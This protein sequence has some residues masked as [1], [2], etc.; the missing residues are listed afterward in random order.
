MC[1]FPKQNLNYDSPSYKAGIKFYNCGCCPE[2]LSKRS[3]SW[4]LRAVYEAKQ[5]A[6]NC[7]V[8]LTYDQFKRNER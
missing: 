7:M 3:S 5:H 4:A 1:L 6:F 2:C 8:T